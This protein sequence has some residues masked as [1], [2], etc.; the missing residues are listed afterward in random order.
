MKKGTKRH[1]LTYLKTSQTGNKKEKI[2]RKYLC[3][4]ECG[5]K[6]EIR[7]CHF[8]RNKSC[9]CAKNKKGEN[10]STFSGYKEIYGRQWWQIKRNTEKR[11]IDFKLTIEEAWALYEKQGRLCKLTGQPI[12]FGSKN[13]TASLDRID[14]N[15]NYTLENV[16]W[17]HKDINKIKMDLSTD[18]FK[19]LCKM[20]THYDQSV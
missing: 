18:Y 6:I 12:Y 20:V 10:S 11:S 8:G 14:S 13:W 7:S 1:G 15:K 3:L 5:N 16:Q 9:G 19:Q 2:P 4:C 17:V